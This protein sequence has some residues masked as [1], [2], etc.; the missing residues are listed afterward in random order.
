MTIFI[1]VHSA[2]LLYAAPANNHAVSKVGQ[3]TCFDR[4]GSAVLRTL[5]CGTRLII[6]EA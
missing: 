2:K 3:L 1:A 5:A 6:L 4:I